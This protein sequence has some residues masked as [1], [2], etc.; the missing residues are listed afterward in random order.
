M[1]RKIFG[2]L[3]LSWPRLLLFSAAMGVVGALAALL[4]PDGW[5]LHEIA[6]TFEF[7]I[8]CAIFVITNCQSAKEAAV[9]TFVFFLISQPL[10]Y[11]IQV[12][13]SWMGWGLFQFYPHWF[14]IT[15]LTLPGAF[16][17]W[18][19]KRN[20]LLSGLILSVM[21]IAL[22]YF[23]VGYL[24]D[25]V[26]N[27]PRHLIS[28]LFCFGQVPLF[29][30]GILQNRRAR[31]LALAISLAA[32]LVFGFLTLRQPEAQLHQ[33]VQLDTEKYPAEAGWT[34]EIE[35]ASLGK[36]SLRD[37]DELGWLLDLE[38][39]TKE[40]VPLVLRGADGEEYR[41]TVWYDDDTGLHIED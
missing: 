34:A 19:I 35:D 14:F 6:V 29:I 33:I 13:F 23:G 40:R 32:L 21:L 41:L 10:I 17:G 31:L 38:L 5:S 26:E 4:V 7:W 30:W 2:G 12:P 3:R 16:I 20:D 11:L 39:Y 18:Y 22:V 9:K 8:L 25:T 37:A 28:T 36:A 24:K 1:I 15:L 27:F